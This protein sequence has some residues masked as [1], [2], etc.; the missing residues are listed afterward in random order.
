[1]EEVKKISKDGNVVFVHFHICSD[2]SE[3]ASNDFPS[4]RK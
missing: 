4:K 3:T 2:Y 1:M